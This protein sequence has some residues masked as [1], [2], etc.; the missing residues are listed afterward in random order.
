MKNEIIINTCKYSLG[1]DGI[2]RFDTKPNTDINL[3]IAK[4]CIAAAAKLAGD[5]KVPLYADM[6]NIRSIDE[7]AKLYFAGAEP[8][9]T[10]LVCAKV[11]SSPIRKVIGN[12]ILFV[13]KPAVPTKLFNCETEAIDWLKTF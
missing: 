12:L 2:L 5:K 1:E 9:K 3:A 10:Q 8:A 11:I 4:E 7:D 13:N 6:R